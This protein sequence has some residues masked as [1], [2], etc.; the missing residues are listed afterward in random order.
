MSW[1]EARVHAWLSQQPRPQ[2]L[3][4]SAMHDAAVL[5]RMKGRPTVC[6]DQ[7]V[8]GVHAVEGI[9]PGKL[10]AKV[11]L[12][13]LS[14]LAATAAYPRAIVL[15][16]AAPRHATDAELRAAI[17]AAR[18]AAQEHGCDVVAGDLSSTDGPWQ[19]TASALG[20]S[21]LTTPPGRD[22]AQAGDALLVTGALGGSILSRHLKPVPRFATGHLAMAHG[23]HALMDVSDGLVLDAS[24]IAAASHVQVR[25]EL[26]RIPVHAHARQLATRDGMPPLEH[27]LRDGED[28]ELLVCIPAAKSDKLC[29]ASAAAGVPL[30]RIGSVHTG[31]GLVLQRHDGTLEPTRPA[32]GGWIHGS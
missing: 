30:T 31:Q 28:H 16:I 5:E 23:A 20:E 32:T 19:I 11:V 18:K 2:G 10:A 15:G 1:N 7:C 13:T 12:R 17:R 27:A 6:V 3:Y 22:R 29:A 9:A 24:R 21:L 26:A 25:L 14:D 4:G 8:E